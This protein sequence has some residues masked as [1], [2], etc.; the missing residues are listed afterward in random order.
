VVRR[1][2]FGGLVAAALAAGLARSAAAQYDP[3]AYCCQNVGLSVTSFVQGKSI[4]VSW[5][6][7]DANVEPAELHAAYSPVNGVIS[8]NDSSFW[9]G[10]I[11]EAPG[12]PFFPG[13]AGSATFQAGA[14][15]TIGSLAF[16]KDFYVQIW[17]ICYYPNTGPIPAYCS[18]QNSR[19]DHEPEFYSTTV[20]VH[21][22]GSGTSSGGSGGSSG[23]GGSAERKAVAFSTT[24]TVVHA[25]GT[26][27]RVKSTTLVDGDVVASYGNPVKISWKNGKIA[28]DKGSKLAYTPSLCCS[29]WTL[30]S[31]EA[32]QQG[33]AEIKA[34]YANVQTESGGSFTIA[35]AN[36][37]DV[38]QCYTGSMYVNTRGASA[39]Q[40][41]LH[42]G[43]Q[44]TVRGGGTYT[45]PKRFVP[46]A[47]QFWK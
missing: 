46:P 18:H 37:A 40:L 43:Q 3:N 9:D 20:K 31:G 19:P 42:A 16:T 25:D 30:K 2:L 23:S 34:T 27:S 28:I 21:V 13:R 8:E 36:G 11:H 33:V 14:D 29:G 39:K 47:R 15:N 6:F 5:T 45:A 26:T 35:E 32:W 41:I 4:S 12:G 22:A 7:A 1:A 10:N 44:T 17:Y 38:V 24:A